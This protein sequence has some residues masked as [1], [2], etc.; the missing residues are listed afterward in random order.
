M[1]IGFFLPSDAIITTCTALS[2]KQV[3]QEVA[4]Q[5]ARITS[6]GDREVLH[7]LMERERLG[8]TAMGGGIAIPHARFAELSRLYAIFVRLP[9][10]V[11]FDAPDG[12][13]VDLMF[14]LLAPAEGNADHLRAMA[15]V[16]RLLRNSHSCG[17]IRQAVTAEV[18]YNLLTA[19]DEE[20]DS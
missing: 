20:R 16:S 8:S 13:P 2:R 4:K 9:V 1:D 3:L 15:R 7:A 14:A 18:I 11:D 19:E 5:A 6:L 12:K 10:P 17:K